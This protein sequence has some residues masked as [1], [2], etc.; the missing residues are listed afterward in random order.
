VIPLTT[1]QN[2]FINRPFMVKIVQD[3]INGLNQDSAGN[4]LQIR[5]LS[6]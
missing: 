5:S 2:K 1:G 3:K 6:T 4:V